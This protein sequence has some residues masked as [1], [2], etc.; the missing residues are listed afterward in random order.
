MRKLMYEVKTVN[1]ATFN[2]SSYAEATTGGNKIKRTYLESVDTRTEK[3]IAE[4]VKRA[5][6]VQQFI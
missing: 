4:T 2:T 1:G 5:N 3:E 6:K